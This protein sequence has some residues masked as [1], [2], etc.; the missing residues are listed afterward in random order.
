MIAT[1]LLSQGVPMISH[2]AELGRTQHGNTGYCQDNELTWI[3]WESL[4]AGLMAFTQKVTAPRAAHPV[5]RRIE[6]AW[7]R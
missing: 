6:P 3:D 4:D 7:P 2:G 5:F 1:L